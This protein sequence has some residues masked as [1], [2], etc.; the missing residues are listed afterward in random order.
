MRAGLPV[1]GRVPERTGVDAVHGLAQVQAEV[2]RRAAATAVERDRRD[3]AR[4]QRDADAGPEA[5]RGGQDGI[6]A[7]ERHRAPRLRHA[8][9]NLGQQAVERGQGIESGAV[10]PRQRAGLGGL[11]AHAGRSPAGAADVAGTPRRNSRAATTDPAANI[12]AAHQNAVV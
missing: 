11:R 8:E 9:A 6:L 12:P 5:V 1:Q 10:A 3:R 4:H 2:L 7:G